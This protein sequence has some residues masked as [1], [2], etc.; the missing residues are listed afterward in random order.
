MPRLRKVDPSFR[1]L[2]LLITVLIAFIVSPLS[3]GASDT[4]RL[5]F[6]LSLYLLIGATSSLLTPGRKWPLL[7]GIL[8]TLAT[9]VQILSARNETSILL[10]ISASVL[11]VAINLLTLYIVLRFVLFSPA[12]HEMDRVIGATCGYFMLV[13]GWSRIF[14]TLDHLDPAAFFYA[15]GMTSAHDDFVYFS[16]VTLTTLGYGDITPASPVARM[17]ASLESIVGTLYVA[18]IIA[19][20]VSR[21]SSRRTDSAV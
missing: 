8:V 9:A 18:I 13:Y 21:V 1:S 5:G 6:A 19:S 11:P 17:F 16:T 14:E 20:L 15:N 7:F 2:P 3:A 12:I 4:F 10:A